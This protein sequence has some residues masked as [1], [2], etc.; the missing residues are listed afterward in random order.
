MSYKISLDLNVTHRHVCLYSER[1]ME[2]PKQT[3][4][5]L[6]EE[7]RNTL[8]QAARK[9]FSR[10]SLSEASI[11][12]IIKEA[13]I[14]RGSFYQY[15]IDKED[16]Y[17]YLLHD[18]AQKRQQKFILFLKKNDGNLFEAMLETLRFMLSEMENENLKFYKNVFLNLNY[19]TEKIFFKSINMSKLEFHFNEMKHHLKQDNL[20]IMNNDELYYIVHIMTTMLIQNIV[21]KFAKDIS[22]EQ[23]LQQFEIQMKLVRVGFEKI[24]HNG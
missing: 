16:L 14:P 12:N 5:N 21:Y 1:G 23:I 10:A 11:S 17:L 22:N 20:N 18:L 4:F 2:V 13:N 7:K 3:F 9:E 8:I 24:E 6:S 19:R 15:F